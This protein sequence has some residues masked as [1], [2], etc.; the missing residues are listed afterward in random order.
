MSQR[1]ATF[2]E[3]AKLLADN[4]QM[5]LMSSSDEPLDGDQTEELSVMFREELDELNGNR[6]I[7]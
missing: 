4:A 2:R 3:I 1:N 7:R 6:R 5:I